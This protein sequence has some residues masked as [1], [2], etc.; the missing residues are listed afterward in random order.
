M[1]DISKTSPLFYNSAFHVIKPYLA[2]YISS[3]ILEQHD[4]Q[5]KE[6]CSTVEQRLAFLQTEDYRY[7]CEAFQ[8]SGNEK[9]AHFPI[10]P[11]GHLKISRMHSV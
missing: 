5:F 11:I 1:D 8:I 3:N 2:S 9:R 6:V 7:F 10:E 4:F